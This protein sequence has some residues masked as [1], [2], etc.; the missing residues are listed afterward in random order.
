M[1][2][3]VSSARSGGLMPSDSSL[4][5]NYKCPKTPSH[6]TMCAGHWSRPKTILLRDMIPLKYANSGSNILYSDTTHLHMVY[7]V[8]KIVF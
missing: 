1:G 5:K 8:L 7:R 4:E 3:K 6:I 2:L